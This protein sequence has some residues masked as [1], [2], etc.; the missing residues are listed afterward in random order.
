MAKKVDTAKH[1]K[2]RKKELANKRDRK[3]RYIRAQDMRLRE[4]VRKLLPSCPACG[5][6]HETKAHAMVCYLTVYTKGDSDKA[7]MVHFY[8]EERHL[9]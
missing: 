7:K 2:Q 4:K 5:T 1:R 8:I 9:S 3:E 6:K